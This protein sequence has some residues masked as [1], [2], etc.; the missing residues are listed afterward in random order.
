MKLERKAE[1]I[2]MLCCHENNFTAEEYFEDLRKK[3]QEFKSEKDY[4]DLSNF[5][6]A[7]SS[8]ERLII[9]NALKEKDRCVCE[10]EVIL[11]KS[12]S[13]VS[14]HLRKLENAG[15][16]QGYKNGNYTYYSLEKQ[17]LR[18]HVSILEL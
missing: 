11:D 5:G 13:T 9:L 2:E 12:Q 10:L 4:I 8:V 16:V 7:I 17:N 6:R 3:G 18:K 1:I 15:L 14:H